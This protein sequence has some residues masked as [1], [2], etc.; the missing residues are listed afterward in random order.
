[1]SE[2]AVDI[3]ILQVAVARPT[4]VTAR[5]IAAQLGHSERAI[6]AQMVRAKN[7]GWFDMRGETFYL[8]P[9]GQS[10]IE[11]QRSNARS[12]SFDEETR[13]AEAA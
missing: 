3:Q 11:Q 12:G 6:S 10:E 1:M 4:G 8:T 7:K 13:E 2:T 9:A 5:H